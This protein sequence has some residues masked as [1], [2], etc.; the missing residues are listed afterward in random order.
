MFP[1]LNSGNYVNLTY[2]LRIQLMKIQTLITQLFMLIYKT[3]LIV[4]VKH[5]L[6]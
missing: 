3:R 4:I 1:S 6:I 5:L 2:K